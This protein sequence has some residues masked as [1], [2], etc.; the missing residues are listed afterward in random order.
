MCIS[1]SKTQIPKVSDEEF[2]FFQEKDAS[3]VK[4]DIAMNVS[5]CKIC[6]CHQFPIKGDEQILKCPMCQPEEDFVDQI[7]KIKDGIKNPQHFFFIF[8]ATYK[9]K[10]II[11]QLMQLASAMGNE[12]T[13]TVIGLSNFVTIIYKGNLGTATLYTFQ[14]IDEF[15]VIQSFACTRKVL[16]DNIIPSLPSLYNIARN[17]TINTTFDLELITN[18]IKE[19]DFVPFYTAICYIRRETAVLTTEEA[20]SLGNSILSDNKN[21]IHFVAEKGFKR[22]SAIS[23]LS[24]GL[25]LK[26]DLTDE[27]FVKNIVNMSSRSILSFVCPK[28]VEISHTNALFKFNNKQHF[29]KCTTSLI[30]GLAGTFKVTNH[31]PVNCINI[32][33]IFNTHNGKCMKLH[34]FKENGEINQLI[35]RELKL[36]L[37]VASILNESWRGESILNLIKKNL[38]KEVTE[39]TPL[40]NLGENPDEDIYALYQTFTKIGCFYK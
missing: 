11:K 15:R 22:I 14:N 1:F 38:T 35:L 25:V 37:V 16:I 30:R 13:V 10:Y 31:S 9:M 23:R 21:M 39:G 6:G 2:G 5:K 3:D 17:Q 27:Q 26:P 4:Y 40:T 19:F 34:R 29:Y 32:I 7:V 12:Q 24:H 28:F 8:D 33:E 20:V 36:R 18:I